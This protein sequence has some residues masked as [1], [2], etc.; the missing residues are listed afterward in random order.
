MVMNSAYTG[1]GPRYV[2]DPATS[3]VVVSRLY[4]ASFV[5]AKGR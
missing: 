5:G 1:T 4:I 3:G 2:P